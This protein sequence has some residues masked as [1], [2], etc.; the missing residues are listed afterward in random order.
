MSPASCGAPLP[1]F[2][3]HVRAGKPVFISA[4][5]D[6]WSRARQWAADG[7]PGLVAPPDADP[8]SF[9]WPIADESVTV[10]A[11]DLAREP[12]LTLLGALA[13]A[14]PAILFILHG[15][16]EADELSIVRTAR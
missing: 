4:G 5:P 3:N 14:K 1:P 13:A 7:H 12:L 2:A 8:W 10:I 16:A 11:T 15:P 6:A 9:H